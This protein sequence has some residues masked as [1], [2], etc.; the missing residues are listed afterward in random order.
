MSKIKLKKHNP[1]LSFKSKKKVIQALSEAMLDGDSEAVQDILYGFLSTQN[2]KELAKKTQLSRSTIYNAV[3][4]N[5]S[6]KTL[7]E[8]LNKAS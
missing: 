5:P 6:L 7:V 8:I 1:S 2:K 3:K 4:G